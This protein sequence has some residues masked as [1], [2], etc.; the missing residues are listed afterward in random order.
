[1]KAK[2]K[3]RDMKNFE[4]ESFIRDPEKED[5]M[6]FSDT[7]TAD[8]I[9]EKIQGKPLNIINK[10]DLINAVTNEEAQLKSKL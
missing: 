4:K 10:H 7:Y 2:K 9:Y 6:E 3:V 8:K 1:M 5:L